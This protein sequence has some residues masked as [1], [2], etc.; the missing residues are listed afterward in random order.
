[1]KLQPDF[2]KGF[3]KLSTNALQNYSFNEVAFNS[4]SFL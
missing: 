3:L 4:R 1:M 2:L